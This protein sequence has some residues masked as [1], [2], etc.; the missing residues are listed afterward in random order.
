KTDWPQR[1]QRTLCFVFLGEFLCS[2]LVFLVFF[3]A[4]PS[5]WPSWRSLCER[6][7]RGARAEEI[8]VAV[9]VVD[10]SDA[11]PELVGADKRQ[12]KSGLF[13]RVGMGPVACRNGFGGMGRVLQ[14]VVLAVRAT[15]GHRL[16][17]A[18]DLN[19][20]VAESIQLGFVL[21]LG[22]FHHQ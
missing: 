15:A 1:S 2:N 6:L 7:Y 17:F 4:N 20:C 14:E 18:P 3:V 10:S 19:H 11:R 21:A 12:R 16:D 8:P 5:V 13:P 22:R 9:G